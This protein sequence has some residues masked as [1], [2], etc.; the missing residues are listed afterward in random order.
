MT[1]IEELRAAYYAAT[2]GE[3]GFSKDTISGN[4]S[5]KDE[6]DLV[7]CFDDIGVALTEQDYRNAN[8]ITLAH[9]NMPALLEAVEALNELRDIVQGHLDDG[10]ELDSL[11]L[12]P[13]RAALAKLKGE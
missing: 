2:P 13:A 3:W 4:P 6:Q 9:N 7:C 12:Q 1:K 10:D 8:F 5:D 11:T